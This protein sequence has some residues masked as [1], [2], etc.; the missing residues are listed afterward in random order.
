MANPNA[1]TPVAV[2]LPKTHQMTDV[3]EESGSD[4]DLTKLSATLYVDLPDFKIQTLLDRYGSPWAP[5][6]H[7]DALDT[8]EA[9][10]TG[11]LLEGYLDSILGA[12]ALVSPLLGTRRC[13]GL[14]E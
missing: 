7:L 3:D 2:P 12:E 8:A 10:E 14:T 9:V 13:M 1:V 4:R 11:S 6:D 5:Q